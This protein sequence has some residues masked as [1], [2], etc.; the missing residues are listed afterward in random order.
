MTATGEKTENV[1]ACSDHASTFGGNPVCCAAALSVLKR[2]DEKLLAEVREKSDYIFQTLTGA[3]GIESVSGMGLMI[4]VKTERPARELVG[5]MIEKGVLC[6]TAK[7]KLRLL[8]ALNIPMEQL[9]KAVQ[10]IRETCAE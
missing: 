9:K 8:P 7:D 1:F 3:K 5:K 4:G 2:I 6:L 10:I